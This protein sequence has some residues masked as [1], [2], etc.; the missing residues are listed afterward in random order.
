M[1]KRDQILVTMLC[2]YNEAVDPAFGRD[3][4]PSGGDGYPHLPSTWN[5]SYRELERCLVRLRDRLPM[6]YQHL[7]TRY[8]DRTAKIRVCAVVNG[9]PVLPDRCEVAAGQVASGDRFAVLQV[10]TWPDWVREELVRAGLLFV[11]R[12]FRGEP[13]LPEEFTESRAA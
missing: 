9:K 6:A 2:R 13:F 12:E 1:N 5:A 8:V 11:S 3:G 7:V 4:E 10:M